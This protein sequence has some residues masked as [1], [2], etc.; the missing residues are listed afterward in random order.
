MRSKAFSFPFP[1]RFCTYGLLAVGQEPCRT[2]RG[3][4]KEYF[5]VDP[6]PWFELWKEEK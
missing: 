5:I 2:C 4:Y 1:C 3:V 6:I